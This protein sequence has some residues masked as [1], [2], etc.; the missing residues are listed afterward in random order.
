MTVVV[1]ADE[2]GRILI[3]LEFRRR[4]KAKRFKVST[5]GEKIELEPIKSPN[6]LRGK[7][8]QL[9]RSEWEDLEEKGEELVRAGDR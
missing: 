2:K 6:E 9:I 5:H 8:R 1:E 7:Y 3:P 4:I